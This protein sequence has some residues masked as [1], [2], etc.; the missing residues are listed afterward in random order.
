MSRLLVQAT[1]VQLAGSVEHARSFRARLRGLLGRDGLPEGAALVI[2]PCNSVH[3]LFMRFAIDVAFLDAGG[4][5]VALVR[6]LRPW[7]ATRIHP[8]ARRT[9]ELPAG[10]L[11]RSGV[12]EGDVLVEVDESPCG[13]V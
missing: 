3:T 1:G 10:A 13:T 12:R 9:V 11:E 8:S 4:G 5:V 7:R 2:D 6:G